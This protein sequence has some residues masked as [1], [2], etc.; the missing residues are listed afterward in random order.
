MNDT[1]KVNDKILIKEG[2]TPEGSFKYV[3]SLNNFNEPIKPA[4]SR[5]AFKTQTI[6]FFKE[7]DGT[8]YAFTKYFAVNIE[9]ALNSK[10]L[11]II[12]EKK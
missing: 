3:Q 6:L 9:P 10:E 12:R 7:Q 11:E 5:M 8:M 1:L 2:T 4:S